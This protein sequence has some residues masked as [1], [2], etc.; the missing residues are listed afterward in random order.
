MDAERKKTGR[1]AWRVLIGAAVGL[2]ILA[3]TVFIFIEKRNGKE[4]VVYKET[5]AEYG[6]LTVG[7][8]KSG[9][10]D[11]GTVEQTFDL[12]MSAL[13]RVDTENTGEA[14]VTQTGG[15]APS[16]GMGASGGGTPDFFSQML[17][18]AGNLTG[19]GDALSLTVAGVLVSV[20]QQVEE[21][22]TLYEIEEESVSGLEQELQ[23]NV[24]KGTQGKKS[25]H[26]E[27]L[28]YPL[29]AQYTFQPN[30]RNRQ[31]TKGNSQMERIQDRR[32]CRERRNEKIPLAGKRFPALSK[33]RPQ[34]S[35]IITTQTN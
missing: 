24:E 31:S 15:M 13:Q 30:E 16:G 35:E 33:N 26:R 2:V 25:H 8:T 19:T 32:H 21:G 9:S 17:G 6:V 3:V 12:D 18:G 4:N 5:R 10:V 23:T 29:P 34:S 28:H 1:A 14:A 7:I 22:D 20:G 27:Y 11:I